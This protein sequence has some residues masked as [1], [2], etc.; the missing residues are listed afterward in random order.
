[1]KN[2]LFPAALLTQIETENF[3]MADS[4]EIERFTGSSLSVEAVFEGRVDVRYSGNGSIMASG[5]L[6]SN[7][8]SLQK[9]N[10]GKF[11]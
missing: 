5:E 10:S 8:N 6:P 11:R 2:S 1:M 4:T 9:I 7:T 3:N